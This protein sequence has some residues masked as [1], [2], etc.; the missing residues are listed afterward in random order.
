[1]AKRVRQHVN[2]LKA[3]SLTRRPPLALPAGPA[4]EA[5]LGCGDARFLIERAR[6]EPDRLFVGID[7]RELFL[8]D[9]RRSVAELR[10]D[11][12]QLEVANLIVDADTLF[13]AGR[14][15]RFH[16][17]FPDPWFKRRQQNRRWLTAE[18]L[19]ALVRALRPG[20][21]LH[22]QSDVWPLLLEAFALLEGQPELAN[23][24]GEWTFCKTNP[25]E[26]ARSQREL[27]CDALGRPYWRLLFRRSADAALPDDDYD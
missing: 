15:S 6:S 26:P 17:N 24:C 11:N 22:Y 13:P 19:A 10:L 9:A 20:G 5:E 23:V 27:D 7:I 1:M 25:F 14:V 4:V 18:T 8:A 12:V 21:E 3:T 2:P 16:I